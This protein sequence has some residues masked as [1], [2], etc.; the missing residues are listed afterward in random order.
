[1]GKEKEYEM[2]PGFFP[3][4]CKVLIMQEEVESQSDGGMYLPDTAVEK[5]EYAV[6][7]GII[8]AFGDGFFKR[9]MDGPIPPIGSKVLYDK[10]AGTRLR[11]R[12]NG[13]DR[14][15]RMMNDSNI[16]AIVEE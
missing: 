14:W 15:V 12:V 6:N 1:M 5:Q 10:Y 2:E 3:V 7:R 16:A 4:D 13:K 11:I 8:I 9:Q